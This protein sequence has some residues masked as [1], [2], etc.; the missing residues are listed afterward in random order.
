MWAGWGQQ[1]DGELSDASSG[2]DGDYAVAVSARRRRSATREKKSNAVRLGS[3]RVIVDAGCGSNLISVKYL[4][5]AGV[6]DRISP[7]A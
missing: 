5:D 3:V 1:S 2:H 7:L 4:R 6:V